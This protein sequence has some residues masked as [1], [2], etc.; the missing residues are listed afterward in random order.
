MFDLSLFR[1]PAFDGASIA[2]FGLSASMFAMFLYI[3]L[4]IQNTLGYSPQQTGLRFLPLTVVS[5]VVA[6][7][8]GRVSR[9][10][11]LR[12]LFGVGLTLVGLSSVARSAKEDP[13]S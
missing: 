3:T 5:F 9:T 8:A 10:V 6:P 13:S 12:V 4:Y 1:K 11:P 7:I 2:A